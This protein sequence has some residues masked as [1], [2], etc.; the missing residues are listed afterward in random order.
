[1][2]L[3]SIE[4]LTKAYADRPLFDALNFGVALGDKV[5]LVGKNG[6]GKSTLLKILA[7]IVPADNG[8]VTQRKGTTVGYLP[9][10]PELN[11]SATI[12]D[13]LYDPENELAAT[14]LAY[15]DALNTNAPELSSIMDKMEALN[16]WDFE[17]EAKQI[18]GKLG[19][20]DTSK[21]VKNLSGGQ[22][23]R[24]AL[25]KLL[26]ENPE[27]IL[28]DEPTNHLDIE[29]IEWLEK[30]LV[31]HFQT[32]VLI[33]HDRYFLESIT[34]EILELSDRKI[35]RHKGKYTDYLDNKLTRNQIAQVEK[36][37]A[38]HLM[39][40]E[41]DW[42]RRQP[43]ARGTKAK[44]RVDAFD[45]IKE[46]AMK[47]LS[48][49][50]MELN[51]KST[52]QGKKILEL[53]DLGHRFQDEWLFEHFNHKFARGERIGVVGKN[54][55]GKSTFLNILTQK[56][57]PQSG[58][59]VMGETTSFGYY[60]QEAVD[61]KPTNRIIDEVR[62]ITE[63]IKLADGSKLSVPKFL[64]QFLFDRKQQYDFVESLSGGERK[65][66]QLLKVLLAEPNFLIL[67]EPTN[68]FDV[69]TLNVLEEYLSNYDGG[70]LVVTHDRYF[71]D[72]L[73]DHLFIFEGN[74][75]IK[76]FPGNYTDYRQEKK[77]QPSAKKADKEKPSL[78]AP[79]KKVPDTKAVKLTYNE[80]REYDQL[81]KQIEELEQKKKVI[82]DKLGQGSEDHEDLIQWGIDIQK[83]D[84]EIDS[85]TER[86]MEL[87]EK[88]S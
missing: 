63:Y 62:E 85:K 29:A 71:L 81:E 49:G 83:L 10:E 16:A 70:L 77:N 67:D 4:G 38:S 26:L 53:H 12:L 31:D 58:S 37:K 2:N 47:N 18:V 13:N 72:R 86:W 73:V 5:A 64:E 55:S 9:Q 60:T 28:L 79:K 1:M 50:S 36:D 69:D 15:E 56:L 68:D 8:L 44:Y 87:G 35:Y 48:E 46:K 61:L 19:I 20:T 59:V 7:H 41:L 11:E 23:K 34:D 75:K 25:A 74:G 27:V 82:V 30:F 21:Q 84:K 88:A 42:L 52:R 54:G 22:K 14:V 45:G 76:D 17:A 39:K 6:A 80:Q 24:V 32:I 65:R 51:I 57:K 33:T 43:Q 78:Q 40:K 66:L 3:I